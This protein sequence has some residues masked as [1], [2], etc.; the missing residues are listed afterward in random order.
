MMDWTQ[1]LQLKNKKM[2]NYLITNHGKCVEVLYFDA[3]H[4]MKY[5]DFGQG[6]KHWVG[7]PE[8]KDWVS[9]IYVP[10]GPAQ[11]SEEQILSQHKIEENAIQIGESETLPLDAPASNC[12]EV[13]QGIPESEQPTEESNEVTSEE[14]PKRKRIVKTK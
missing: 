8:Y 2:K 6:D 10:D 4:K 3:D 14:K 9:P 5:V 1:L 13:E 12:R 7:E 11:M